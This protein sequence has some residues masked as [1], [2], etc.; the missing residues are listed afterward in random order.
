MSPIP[1]K[2]N[3]FPTEPG[4]YLFADES[5][6]PQLLTVFAHENDGGK[7]YVRGGWTVEGTRGFWSERLALD[8]RGTV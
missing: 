6:S 4:R 2:L 1:L 8:L 3:A 5:G 7:L